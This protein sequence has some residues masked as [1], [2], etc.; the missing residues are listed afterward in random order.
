MAL[1]KRLTLLLSMGL[2]ACACPPAVAPS[3]TTPTTS[4][5]ADHVAPTEPAPSGHHEHGGHH[6]HGP[7]A[8]GDTRAPLVHRFDDTDPETWAKRFE[9]DERDA[10]QKP[11]QVVKA[12]AL[13]TGMHV[14]DIGTGTGYFLPRL[15]KAVG[16]TGR[17]HAV[18]IAPNMVR[19]V[20]TRIVEDDLSN[21]SVSLALTDDPL[22]DARSLD[23][24]LIVNT[25]HHIAAREAYSQKLAEA[26]KPGGEVF[27]VDFKRS[28]A[29]GPDKEHKLEPQRVVEEL[30][31]A[32]LEPTI[33]TELL[34]DQY[35]VRAVKPV[36]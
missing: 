5:S 22:L 1:L 10:Y 19:H 23:R 36:R 32:G 9:S 15:S 8:E 25:W 27:V 2:S 30:R 12:M 4:P 35:V 31:A 7:S 11:D 26:L 29:R 34:S 13:T 6:G 33:D 17:V 14:A 18:D 24:I 20:K 28:S 3:P 21:V 16:A